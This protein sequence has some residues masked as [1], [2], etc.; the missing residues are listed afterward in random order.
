MF[1]P[2]KMVTVEGFEPPT[3]DLED[4]CSIQLNYTAKRAIRRG[5]YRC[6]EEKLRRYRC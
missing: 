6:R 5:K 1:S 3:H 2:L 4:R